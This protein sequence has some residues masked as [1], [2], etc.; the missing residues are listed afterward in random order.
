MKK[1]IIIAIAFTVCLALCT[2]VWPQS[3]AAG[4]VPSPSQMTAVRTQA[5]TGGDGTATEV[6]ITPPAEEEKAG[7]PRAE[8]PHEIFLKS[9]PISEKAPAIA[10]IQ[11]VPEPKPQQEQESD[12]APPPAQTVTAPQTGDLAY[13]PGFG[14]LESQGPGETIHD[15]NIYENGN[16]IGTM[17]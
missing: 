16:K 8:P 12:S 7:V 4:E 17:G 2:A 15:E 11:P 1:Y 13:V 3:E 14:W 10:E 5:S 6:R 9:E